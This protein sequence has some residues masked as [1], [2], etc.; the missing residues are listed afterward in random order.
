[1]ATPKFKK[2]KTYRGPQ[3]KFFFKTDPPEGRILIKN[4]IKKIS[5][6]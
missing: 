6:T 5:I 4:K 2:S 3:I 1:M